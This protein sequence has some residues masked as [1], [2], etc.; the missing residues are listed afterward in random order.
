M[1]Q[2]HFDLQQELKTWEKKK[3]KKT[4]Q[5]FDEKN[6]KKLLEEFTQSRRY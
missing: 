5:P 3:Q 2:K 6:L 1:T 4:F